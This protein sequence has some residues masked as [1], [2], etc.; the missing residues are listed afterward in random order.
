M[1]P[2]AA[3]RVLVQQKVCISFP[4]V[5][6]WQAMPEQKPVWPEMCS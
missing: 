2:R 5:Q 3:R 6:I 1:G 4:D